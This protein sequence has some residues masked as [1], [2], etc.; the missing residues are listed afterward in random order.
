MMKSW[1]VLLFGMFMIAAFA[2]PVQAQEK[3]PIKVGAIYTFTGAM[4]FLNEGIV[5]GHLLAIDEINK[6]GGL[7]GRKIELIKRD[8]AGKADLVTRYSRELIMREKVDFI[9]GGYGTIQAMALSAVARDFK[10]PIFIFGGH[11]TRI[12]TEDWSPYHFRYAITTSAEGKTLAKI[13]A[14]EYLKG[15][16]DPKVYYETWDFEFGRDVHR[17][18]IPAIKEYVPNVKI[19]E[20][21]PRV[22]ETDYSPYISQI[23]AYKPHVLAHVIF[24]GGAV[25]NLKQCAQMG[26]FKNTKLASASV[27]ASNEYR[28]ILKDAIPLGSWSWC[29]DDESYPGTE[30]QKEFYERYRKWKGTT[31]RVVP[32][33]VWPAYNMIKL[34]EAAV[35]KAGTLE[36]EAVC[37]AMEGIKIDTYNGPVWI[38]DFDHQ[39]VSG[40]IWGPLVKKPGSDELILDPEKTR[41]V[42]VEPYLFTKEE[43]HAARK[44]AGIE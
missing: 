2:F 16:K 44:A 19:Y 17:Y 15:V 21:W 3:D 36:S 18:F 35:R 38:R 9:V 23:L 29:Y 6:S 1:G 27:V 25:A 31:K 22:G 13:I 33:H 8:D 41:Y 14:E 28:D 43:W 12:T 5:D 26:V 4:A 30:E 34:W 24:A 40:H 20:G 10:K 37:K 42:P 39:V 32:S 11:S 7:L